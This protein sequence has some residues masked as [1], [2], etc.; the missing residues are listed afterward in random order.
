MP[1]PN[2]PVSVTLA[3][4]PRGAGTQ[5]SA[6]FVAQS[7]SASF[8]WGTNPGTATLVYLAPNEEWSVETGA[9]CALTIGAHYFVGICMSDVGNV[10]SHEGVTRTLEFS[11]LRELLKWDYVFC[12]FNKP[13]VVLVNGRRI[14]RY[15]HIYP[16]DY[17]TLTW[18]YTNTPLEAWQ[19]LAAILN[20]RAVGLPGGVPGGTIGSPWSWDLTGMELFPEGLFNYPI[21]DFDCLNGTRLD[22]VLNTFCER[23]GC[24]VGLFST[25]A[26]AYQLVFTRKGYGVSPTFPANADNR[27][28]GVALSG[29]ATNVRVLGERNLYQVMNVP[30]IA[31]WAEG[32]EQF[33]VFEQF[34]DDIYHRATDPNTGNTYDQ[35]P[36]DPEGY[37]GWQ[38]A[39]ARAKSITVR[40]YVG[41]RNQPGG[42]GDGANFTDNRKFAG[43]WRM[44][45]LAAIY[46]QALLWRA[47]R[48]DDSFSL[49][50]AM[51]PMGAVPP[52]S[53]GTGLVGSGT[54]V[55][56]QSLDLAD[57][58]LCKVYMDDPTTGNLLFDVTTPA[59]GNGLAI[60]RG[61]YVS[62]DL[63]RDIS[64]AQFN[65]NFFADAT[66]VWV[67]APFQIDD[68]GEETR[69]I[70]FDEPV[71]L[72]ENLVV[73]KDG[74]C[75][76]NAQATLEVPSTK[77]ALIFEAERFQYVQGTYPD[78]SRD[79][80]ENVGGLNLEVVIDAN[81][82]YTEVPFADNTSAYAK[83]QLVA[84][85]TLLRQ[86]TYGE[87]G[88]RFIW[89][90]GTPIS[91]FGYALSSMI[92]RVVISTSPTQGTF[93]VVDLTNER[94]RDYFEPERDLE[95]KT[96]GNSLF[97]G[98]QELRVQA[99]DA[100]KLAAAFKQLPGLRQ[101]L[102]D[103]IAGQIGSE[104]PVKAIKLV[105]PTGSTPLPVGTV[106]RK[107][108]T[109]MTTAPHS[110][111]WPVAPAHVSSQHTVF[112][113]VTV[114]DGENPAKPFRVQMTGRA[115]ALVQGPVK[116]N[117]PVGLSDGSSSGTNN[118]LV[119]S[120][121][122]PVGIVK[123]DVTD[124]NQHLVEVDLGAGAAGQPGSPSVFYFKQAFSDYLLATTSPSGGSVVQIAKPPELRCSLT[125]AQIDGEIFSMTY[126]TSGALAWTART[127][128]GTSTPQE[129]QRVRPSY[130]PG[131]AAATPPI[132]PSKINAVPYTGSDVLSVGP[133]DG[134]STNA[135]GTPLKWIQI[136][137]NR[138]WVRKVDQTKP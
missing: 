2:I 15:K 82:N 58:M 23:S 118:C 57:K 10:G 127:K 112:A 50:G 6:Q 44:D 119:G 78:V 72:S 73:Q 134:D 117:D 113:G 51:M 60:A 61:Y 125:T 38:L 54:F 92:D 22:S 46:I 135:A 14:K 53:G 41:L 84:T 128:V 129:Y 5:S 89:V 107:G 104:Q 91:Q 12:A 110:D 59:D 3:L 45:L 77:A 24:V 131:N 122:V 62:R 98:Q 116:T 69:F 106:L 81:G 115:L 102:S 123:Q 105:P 34:A 130:Q 20:Y 93:E 30:L 68:S 9:L 100:R 124:S 43:R 31:D 47:F 95:R 137:E 75:V 103:L 18:T 7:M 86:Y 37:I 4:Q 17:P 65:L 63:F 88:F 39:T 36:N 67:Q 48:P 27:R 25:P 101:D 8:A 40:D 108:Q 109:N 42:P 96:Q 33:L 29:N 87:G 94:R 52:S 136:S 76:I 79:S 126:Q 70:I 21:Y 121:T 1:V 120:P 74:H 32:W 64:S 132:P 56:P 138:M 28:S 97:P 19:M 66:A 83:A 99:E 49:M 13:D 71:I 26:E 55:P 35:T 90:P 16:A 80:V 85:T 11:D 114:R 133:A 111:T